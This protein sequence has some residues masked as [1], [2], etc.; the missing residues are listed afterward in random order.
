MYDWANS[1]YTTTVSVALL[2]AYFAAVVVGPEGFSV[3]GS[4]Y[5]A[6]ALWGFVIGLSSLIAFLFAPVLGAIS[7]FSAAK[8]KFLLTFAFCGALFTALMF[9]SEAGDVFSTLALILLAQVCF[10]GANVFYDAFL[11]E[12]AS[13]GRMNWVSGKGYSFGYI[14]GG[15]QF[16]FSLVL[17]AAHESLGLT[18]AM[19]VRVSILTAALW[20]AGFSLFTAR[21]LREGA[22][23]ETIP[24]KYLSWPRLVAWSAIGISRTLETTRRVAQFRHLVLFLIAFML[25]DDG[26]QT[27]ILMASIYGIEE[28]R[29]SNTDIMVTLLVIQVIAT[30]GAL[31]F[32]RMAS[33]IGT[34]QTIMLSL[35]LWS[36]VVSFA[37]FI[38]SATEFFALG[39]VVGLVLGGS[40]ALSR[41][42]YASMVPEGA[43]AEFFGFYT[44]FSKFSAIWGP[45]IFGIIRQW[46]GSS[47]LAIV[48]LVVFFLLGLILLSFVDETKARAAKQ[49]GVFA[50]SSL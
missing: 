7:D 33:R 36:G 8:K 41:S 42:F 3:G 47:R 29:L 9:F 14:G 17:V 30:F 22:Q 2:P 24:E 26:I 5:S 48:S 31:I 37:Y 21:L 10:I 27:V 45:L 38:Q 35:V 43:S 16:T 44:V 25:Y 1:A 12:V 11:P 18:Q 28:L 15:L 13:P 46:A 23:A 39:V 19:A 40:Q 4:T 6:T 50:T 34:K 32:T 20:W 49:K